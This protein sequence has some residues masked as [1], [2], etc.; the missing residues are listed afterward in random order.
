MRERDKNLIIEFIKKAFAFV[1]FAILTIVTLGHY[2]GP[3]NN[4]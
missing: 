1:V 4:A 3:K 2:K